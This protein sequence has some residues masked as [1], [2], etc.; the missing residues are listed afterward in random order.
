M[1][2]IARCLAA[3]VVSLSLP[4]AL[5]LIADGEA[6]A[7]DGSTRPMQCRSVGAA[8]DA[9]VASVL[10]PLGVTLRDPDTP[11]GLSCTP[12][13]NGDP[14]VNFCAGKDPVHGIAVI[15]RHPMGHVCP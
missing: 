15:G 10:K 8:R 6:F 14:A 12:V 11:V 7:V 9:D 5:P 2:T 1:K 13:R 3:L 4:L